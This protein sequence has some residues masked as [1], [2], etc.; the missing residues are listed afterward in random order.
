ME[1]NVKYQQI[2]WYPGHMFKSFRVIKENLKIMDLVFILLDARI[3][4]SS[5]NPEILNVLENKKT[6]ILFNKMD[7]ADKKE[8]DKWI[9]HYEDLGHIC[10]AIDAATGKNVNQIKKIA[11]DLLK[12][13]LES[14]LNKGLKQI[15]FKTMVLGIPNVGKSTLINTLSNRKSTKVGN[16]P[17]LTKSKQWVK[18]SNGFDLLDMPGVLWP[19]FEEE[20]VGYNLAITGAIRD[21][22]L[23]LDDVT[24]F[25]IKYLQANY[26]ERLQERYDEAITK[27]SEFVEVLDL[28]GTKRGALIRGGEIDYDRVYMIILNDIR[29]KQLGELSFDLI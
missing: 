7:L 12:Q 5:M 2:N 11:E 15:N 20:K 16:T 26:L 4:Y 23:P 28:I 9:K 21:N 27:D 8:L 19:K 1:K 14:R 24:N 29:S 10:L 25:A 17:G 13:Q 18:L 3:P 22:I 6:F